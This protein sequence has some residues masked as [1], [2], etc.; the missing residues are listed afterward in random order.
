MTMIMKYY[1]LITALILFSCN[2]NQQDTKQKVAEIKSDKC[3][4]YPSVVDS[5]HVQDLYDSAR[6][7]IYT[8]YCDVL[9]KPKS[10]SLLSKPFG[11]LEL[12]FDNLAIKNDILA[13]IFN[14]TDKGQPVLPSMMREYKQLATGVGFDVKTKEKIY[15]ISSNTTISYKGNPKSRYENPLQP[16]VLNYIT[17]NWAKLNDCFRK[18]AEQKGIKK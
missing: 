6:W 17:G 2:S 8:Q 18:L 10:D 9:Y 3:F 14:F 1:F 7:Y 12:K 13:L 5:L 16:E 15:L 4:L 11:E